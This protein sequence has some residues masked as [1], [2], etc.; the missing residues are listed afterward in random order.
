MISKLTKILNICGE[1]ELNRAER[2]LELLRGVRADDRA[3][4]RRTV[5]QPAKR[6]LRHG[7]AARLGDS[8]KRVDD[9]PPALIEIA[10]LDTAGSRA[11]GRRL[12]ACWPI[13]R[14][15]WP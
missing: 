2:L 13:V 12:A 8:V 3:R 9:G 15:A 1:V 6:Y 5:Q 14:S 10:L 7:R 4:D 11:F